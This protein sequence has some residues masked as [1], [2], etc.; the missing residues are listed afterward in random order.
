MDLKAIA[1]DSG[2]AQNQIDISGVTG[3]VSK[4]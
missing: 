2:F 4:D 3:D 1:N